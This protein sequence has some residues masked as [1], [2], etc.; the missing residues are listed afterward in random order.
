MMPAGA[1]RLVDRAGVEAAYD[2]LARRLNQ[3]LPQGEVLMLPVMNGGMFAACEL[4]R[5]IERPMRF[6]YVHATRYR[7]K[8]RGR[9]IEWLHW[10]SLPAHPGPIL[11]IDDIFDEGYTL[12]AIRDRLPHPERVLT[13]ALARKLHDRGLA[14]DWIDYHGVDV[15]DR[16]VFG[17]GMD[18]H[19]N[20]RELPE[21]W[22][23]AG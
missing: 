11:L 22:A 17:C 14:R 12:A 9:E 19:D 18:Y 21:I 8:M 16:Y 7:G 1:E 10:P 4:A 6:D 15:P 5:R 3:A 20:F 2:R 13:V 23:L